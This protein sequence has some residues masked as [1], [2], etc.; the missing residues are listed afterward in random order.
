MSTDLSN[1][2]NLVMTWI[3]MLERYG[4]LFVRNPRKYQK[5]LAAIGHYGEPDDYGV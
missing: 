3:S 4:R 1:F 5:L 2:T